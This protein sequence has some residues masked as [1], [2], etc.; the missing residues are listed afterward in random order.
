MP[1]VGTDE[2]ARCHVGVLPD[3]TLGGFTVAAVK[4]WRDRAWDSCIAKCGFRSELAA[5]NAMEK[6]LRERPRENGGEP[7]VWCC[8]ICGRYHWG[9]SRPGDPVT[10][11]PVVPALRPWV[12]RE[13]AE[14]WNQ[15]DPGPS[16]APRSRRDAKKAA[17]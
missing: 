5:R 10:L 12:L 2:C 15:A 11:P 16:G 13:R 7:S 4:W 1:T 17:R 8:E 6:T 9:H 3:G 14:R